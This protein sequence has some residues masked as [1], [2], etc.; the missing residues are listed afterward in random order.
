MFNSWYKHGK[1]KNWFKNLEYSL[2]ITLILGPF[3]PYF[4]EWVICMQ[5]SWS[6]SIAVEWN[7]HLHIS[8]NTYF[9]M[10]SSNGNIFRVTGSLRGEFAGHTKTSDAELWCFLWYVPEQTVEETIG[11]PVISDAI[12]L[13][14]TSLWC[15]IH[16]PLYIVF[17]RDW[18]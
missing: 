10:T 3:V 6:S 11:T 13:I 8:L 12:M 2:W 14:M 16:V 1:G 9:M 18:L 7:C 5:T 15:A 4:W 17:P